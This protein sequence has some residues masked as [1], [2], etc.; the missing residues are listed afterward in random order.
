MLA[1]EVVRYRRKLM[2]MTQQQLGEKLGYHGRTAELVIQ[3][4]ENHRRQIPRNM[5]RKTAKLL[6]VPV[7][8]LLP[9]P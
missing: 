3:A 8:M 6:K 1:G 9:P 7:D 2:C 5:L 4:W